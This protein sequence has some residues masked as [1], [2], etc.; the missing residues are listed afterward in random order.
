MMTQGRVNSVGII[1]LR[2]ISDIFPEIGAAVDCIS[3]TMTG[4]SD[5]RNFREFSHFKEKKI[6]RERLLIFLMI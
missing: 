6:R 2:T 3:T 5:L 4:S 1:N